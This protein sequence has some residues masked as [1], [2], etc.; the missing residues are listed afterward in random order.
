M[1]SKV[2]L[3]H[4]EELIE[5][6]PTGKYL[7]ISL[8]HA[9][10]D[11]SGKD[12]LTGRQV[13]VEYENTEK[14]KNG[15]LVKIWGIPQILSGQPSIKILRTKEVVKDEAEAFSLEIQRDKVLDIIGKEKDWK[16]ELADKTCNEA[17]D[18]VETMQEEDEIC[19]NAIKLFEEFQY[20]DQVIQETADNLDVVM[21]IVSDIVGNI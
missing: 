12:P 11:M 6:C 15:T 7:Y 2:K 17:L 5:E 16:N 14:P 21:D 9:G 18:M 19:E 10:A 8:M 13:S 3:L 4:L 20:G 1:F